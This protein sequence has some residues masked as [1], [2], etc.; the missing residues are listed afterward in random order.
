MQQYSEFVLSAS[1]ALKEQL[2]LSDFDLTDFNH[3]PANSL[4]LFESR[5]I[6]KI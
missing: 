5:N 2:V 1:I 6:R 4:R 3:L